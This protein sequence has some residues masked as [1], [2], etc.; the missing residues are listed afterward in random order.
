MSVV[1]STFQTHCHNAL[2]HTVYLICQDRPTHGASTSLDNMGPFSIDSGIRPCIENAN[3]YFNTLLVSA[4]QQ[5]LQPV[6]YLDPGHIQT[7]AGPWE[8]HNC[9]R[10]SFPCTDDP[11]QDSQYLPELSHWTILRFRIWPRD[12]VD[13]WSVT[14]WILTSSLQEPTGTFIPSSPRSLSFSGS[15]KAGKIRG[16]GCNVDCD[17]LSVTENALPF[18][19]H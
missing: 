14:S 9:H 11:P 1:L 18:P 4:T 17:V 15:S 12:P 2:A 6:M 5:P 19:T 8:S 3:R 16:V 10:T 13:R 7:S